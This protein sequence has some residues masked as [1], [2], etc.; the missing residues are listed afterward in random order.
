MYCIYIYTQTAQLG[1]R[2]PR[3][4]VSRSHTV[5]HTHTHTH[6]HTHGRTS[7]N[8]RSARCRGRYLHKTQQTQDTNIHALSGIRTRDPSNQAAA[9]LRHKMREHRNSKHMET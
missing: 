8:E 1:P 2:P 5:R 4:E 3:V 9:G 6:T 7:L